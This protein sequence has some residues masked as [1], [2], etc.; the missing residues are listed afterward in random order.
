MS[1]YTPL[2]GANETLSNLVLAMSPS[3]KTI[4][5]IIFSCIVLQK[6]KGRESKGYGGDGPPVQCKNINCPSFTII[7]SEKEFEIR[8]YNQSLWVTSPS[9]LQYSLVGGL[10]RGGIM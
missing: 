5:L 4:L 7:H 8:N 9:I 2:N 3:R 1:V 10:E 6:C